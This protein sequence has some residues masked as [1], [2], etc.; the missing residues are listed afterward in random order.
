MATARVERSGEYR[1]AGGRPPLDPAAPVGS[2]SPKRQFRVPVE[3]DV[4]LEV[5]ARA[6]GRTVS[7]VLR[8]AL[9]EYLAVRPVPR[10]DDGLV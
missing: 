8:S 5:Q 9:E 4:R 1:P 10:A 2:L 7:D 3:L 6:E